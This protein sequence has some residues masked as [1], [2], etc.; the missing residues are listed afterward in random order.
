MTYSDAPEPLNKTIKGA[1]WTI[2]LLVLLLIMSILDRVIIALIRQPLGDAFGIS[3][4]QFGLLFGTAFAVFYATLGL[5]V[6][7]LADKW[8]RKYL[9]LTGTF[10]WGL[11]TLKSGF[12]TSFEELLILRVGLAVGEVALFPAAHSLVADL[13]SER[14][15]VRAASILAATPFLGGALTFLGGG[16]LV[17]A[18][19]SYV[20]QGGGW[21][22]QDWQIVFLMAGAPTIILGVIFGIT[23]SEPARRSQ[24]HLPKRTGSS[25]AHIS[26]PRFFIPLMV[27]AEFP[28]WLPM[29]IVPGPLI[30]S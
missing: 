16:Y 11:C 18:I 5:P 13:F 6:A 19:T 24:P 27:G 21:G 12:A 2:S 30:C 17:S 4:L 14:K 15:R 20:A 9:I 10:L 3:D 7:R 23:V 22:L 25:S 28:C 26:R 29:P 8:N 1:W